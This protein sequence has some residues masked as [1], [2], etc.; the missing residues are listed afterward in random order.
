MP[1][2]AASWWRWWRILLALVV[3]T[4]I[5]GAAFAY[6]FNPLGG[7]LGGF[8]N[9]HFTTLMRTEML[10]HGERPLRDFSDAGLS[11]AWPPLS[12]LLPKWAQELGGRNLLSEA[13]LT[14]GLLALAHALVF[15][16]ALDLSRRWSVA[17]LVTAVAIATGPKLYNYSKVLMLT[18][19]VLAIRTV[20]LNPTTARLF[21]AA[22][23]TAMAALFRNDYAVYIGVASRRALRR[24][25]CDSP[26]AD[27]GRRADVLRNPAIRPRRPRQQSD[28][29]TQNR[30]AM[31]GGA[32]R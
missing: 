8:D 25:W 18:A 1:A 14:V 10:F 19:G 32:P 24:V 5:A 6:R 16:V 2:A 28:R 13:Y 30:A 21:V 3:A 4:L 23:I 7:A 20:A 9:D 11:G 22:A 17:L 31:A 29:G 26:S 15:L 27:S 12:Y